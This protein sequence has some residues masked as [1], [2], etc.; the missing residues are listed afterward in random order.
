MRKALSVLGVNGSPA[1]AGKC[2]RFLNE[3]LRE[4]SWVGANI[5]SIYLAN[6]RKDLFALKHLQMKQS[7]S[8][9]KYKKHIA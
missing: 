7:L 9:V 1:K 3:A 2:A 6:Y 4:S 8:L 5:R